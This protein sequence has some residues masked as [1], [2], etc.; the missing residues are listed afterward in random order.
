MSPE[1]RD[2]PRK[3]S[4]RAKK[5]ARTP[6][7]RDRRPP[8]LPTFLAEAERLRDRA[9]AVLQRDVHHLP[10]VVG[11]RADGDREVIGLAVQQGGPSFGT[12]LA[13]VVK[14]RHLVCFVAITEAWM[15]RGP[16]LDLA[17]M[18]SQS[19]ERQQVLVISAIHPAGKTMWV[20]PF[21]AEGG[22]VVIGTPISSEGMTLG[23][24][25]PDALGKETE[26]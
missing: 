10:I 12:V 20:Y 15:T 24:G 2:P 4:P 13:A 5:G 22:R 8:D 7:R 17:V 19:P 3:T 16:N 1:Q 14:T 26:P 23:G 9:L 11:W 21:A 18:P 6:R 25:I